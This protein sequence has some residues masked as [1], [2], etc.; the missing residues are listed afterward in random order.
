M[1]R[2]F[3]DPTPG[4]QKVIVIDA[5]TL[6]KAEELIESCEGCNPDGAQISIR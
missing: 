1:P 3:F 4:E 2:D 6:S 5:A